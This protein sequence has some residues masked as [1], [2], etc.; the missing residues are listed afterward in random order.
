MGFYRAFTN[1][2][3]VTSL[4]S[5]KAGGLDL[6]DLQ[7][8]GR[9]HAVSMNSLV[10]PG[11]AY[12]ESYEN[13]LLSQVN[14]FQVIKR[15]LWIILLVMLVCAGLAAGFSYSQTPTYETSILVLIGQKQ[16]GDPPTSLQG[17]V[18]GLQQV[19]QTVA[20]AAST[21]PIIDGVAEKLDLDPPTLPGSLSAEPIEG[22]TFVE[23]YYQDTDPKRAQLIANTAGDVLSKRISEVSPGSG[24]TATVW[25][26]ASTPGS[27]VSPDPVRNILL[28]LLLGVMVGVG[29]AFLL[30]YVDDDWT[31]P[32]EAAKVSGVPTFGVIPSFNA[33]KIVKKIKKEKKPR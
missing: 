11:S 7:L 8:N 20:T 33:R 12:G 19:T 15:R 31:S 27:P 18:Y 10:S 17:D 13:A 3:G 29:L 4:Q 23:M 28:G 32:E 25:E 1:T 2:L 5:Q 9:T 24:I 30:D 14:P 22:T 6:S 16:S 21:G 26:E